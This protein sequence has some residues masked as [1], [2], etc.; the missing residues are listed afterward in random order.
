MGAAVEDLMKADPPLIQEAWHRLQ[1]WYKAAVDRPPPPAQ[2]TLKQVT[3]D[4]TTL[5]S[6]VTPP[7]RH[8][9]GHNRTFRGGGLRP[10]RGGSGVGGQMPEKQPRR[11]AVKDAG[12]GPE[13]VAVSSEEGGKGAGGEYQS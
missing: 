10:L 6:R 11:G 1:G 13:R 8:H 3:A 2:A 12:G 4:R 9:P 7:R 5:Y